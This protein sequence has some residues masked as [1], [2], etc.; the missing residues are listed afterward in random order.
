M[1]RSFIPGSTMY[2]KV[3]NGNVYDYF[4]N[5]TKQYGDYPA[6]QHG[7]RDHM[8]SELLA[9]VDALAAYYKYDLGYQPGDVYT[10][11]MSTSI[12]AM[13]LF[14][15]LNK[16]GV[17]V[18]F[19]HPMLPPDNLDEII[20]FTGS[21]GIVL[22]D[23]MAAGYAEVAAAHSLPV[24]LCDFAAY[25]LPDKFSAQPQGAAVDSLRAAGIDFISY[26]DAIKRGLGKNA[27]SVRECGD[28]IAVYMQG[29][30]TTGKSR[31]IMLTNKNLNNVVYMCG[32]INEKPEH[33]G[34]DTDIGCMPFFHAYGF[35]VGGLSSLVKGTKMV[36]LPRFDADK[37]IEIMKLNHV[38]QFNGVPNMFK[39]LMEHPDWDGPQL[40]ALRI[41]F[42]GGD[43]LGAVFLNKF[44]DVCKKNGSI[45]EL[46]QG[47]GLTECC[48]IVLTN[49]IDWD[50][51]GALGKPLP[52]LRVE[53]WD[54]DHKPVPNGTVGEIAI[55]GPTV[56]K[57]YLNHDG[58]ENDGIYFT[59]DGTRWVLTGDLAYKDDDDFFFFAGRKKRVV[60][61]SGYNVY[62]V[63]IE[64]VLMEMPFIK[65]SCPVQGFDEKGKKLIR[66]YVVLEDDAT[67]DKD[68]YSKIITEKCAEKLSKYSVPRDIRYISELPRTRVQ[69]VDFMQMTQFSPSDPIF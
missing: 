38:V 52:G 20:S 21:K 12:E 30:G 24:M 16:I 47:Y 62:P 18:N 25:A 58:I 35:C 29:G 31:T 59:E 26:T 8:R 5:N 44:T 54:E 51:E 17:I 10:V 23:K 34:I 22:L 15:A 28:E 40:A 37:F 27:D 7:Y 60:I 49:P 68:H 69:K 2:E 53:V 39:K 9:D 13:I 55:S 11:F 63:D 43:D 50:K 6:F 14:M 64:K 19:V 41:A 56:M 65:E 3:G 32:C 42:G 33:V 61:I 57:G 66:L 46:H 1:S 4:V 36:F 45:A 67:E 48:A